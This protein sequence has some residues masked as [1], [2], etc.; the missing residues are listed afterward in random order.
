[1]W[2]WAEAILH[3]CMEI[4]RVCLFVV[5]GD[6]YKLATWNYFISAIRGVVGVRPG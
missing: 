2:L 4:N 3:G 5:C 1:M 6:G